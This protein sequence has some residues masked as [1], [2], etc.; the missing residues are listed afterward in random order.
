M[1][2]HY[3]RLADH[4]GGLARARCLEAERAAHDPRVVQLNRWLAAIKFELTRERVSDLHTDLSSASKGH[5]SFGRGSSKR[6]P[7]F[8]CQI[9]P[10]AGTTGMSLRSPSRAGSVRRRRLENL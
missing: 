4:R 3:R 6:N 8:G 10:R 2:V 9:T 1:T 7:E 5:A